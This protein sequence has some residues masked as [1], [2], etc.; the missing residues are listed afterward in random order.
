M[1]S[2]PIKSQT[3]PPMAASSCH[4]PL[5]TQASTQQQ[6]A[7]HMMQGPKGPCCRAYMGTSQTTR[8]P[9]KGGMQSSFLGCVKSHPP[10]ADE[11]SLEKQ[12]PTQ[13]PHIA[14]VSTFRQP[15]QCSTGHPWKQSLPICQQQRHS[16]LGGVCGTCRHTLMQPLVYTYMSM[17]GQAHAAE[18]RC[19]QNCLEGTT[20]RLTHAPHTTQEEQRGRWLASL[21]EYT[22]PATI[23]L[24]RGWQCS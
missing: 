4:V 16:L 1:H 23:N 17:Q 3:S 9:W 2:P 15:V 11:H 14:V 5:P 18:G 24:L 19:T 7:L 8:Q 6:A 20:Q 12:Q 13:L 21:R 10:L 22:H